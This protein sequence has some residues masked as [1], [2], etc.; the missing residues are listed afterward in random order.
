[1]PLR[2]LRCYAAMLPR[3][4]SEEALLGILKLQAADSNLKRQ[5]RERIVREWQRLACGGDDKPRMN[6]EEF[7]AA[8]RRMGVKYVEE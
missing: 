6:K 5:Y 3:L 7:M 8:M 1:M 4:Q 2:W